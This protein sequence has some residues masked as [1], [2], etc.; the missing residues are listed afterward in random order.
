MAVAFGL[1]APFARDEFVEA[2][3][4]NGEIRACQRVVETDEDFAGLDCGTVVYPQ[5]GDHPAGNVPHR[6]HMGRDIDHSLSDDGAGNSR[7][8]RPAADTANQKEQDTCTE[9]SV[10]PSRTQGMA[11]PCCGHDEVTSPMVRTLRRF[12]AGRSRSTRRSTSSLG[13]NACISARPIAATQ[14]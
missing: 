14:S 9:Q 4:D 5:F 8:R 2:L 13:P 11:C 7:R 12:D 3:F 10:A 1:K 6:L